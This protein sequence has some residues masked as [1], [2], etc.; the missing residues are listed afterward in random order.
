VETGAVL[1]LIQDVAAD[2]I[3]P[4]F[5]SL[6]EHQVTEKN[7]GD[8][9]TIADHESEELLTAALQEAYPAAVVLG[10]EAEGHDSGLIERFATAE[11][12]FTV[13]PVD[14]TKNF[15]SG[16][17]DHAV[18]VAETRA[19]SVTRSWI[20]QPQHEAAYVAERGA[21]AWLNGE[22]L[23]VPASSDT[24]PYRTA[25]RAWVGRELPGL[26]T[27]E[28]TWAC[29]GIDYPRLIAG[30]AR[31]I[32]YNHSKPWDHLPGALLLEEAGGHIGMLDGAPFDA[33]ALGGGLVGAPDR[34][35]YDAVV[36]AFARS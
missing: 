34:A 18:M 27:L 17:P 11:H 19:G 35:T 10:E 12:G 25:R 20:W 13:D 24:A 22:P 29:C 21:G 4:R 9:V 3:T 23:R 36:A 2:V 31:A 8:L 1:T 30:D 32:V 6:A 7:P 26:G 5:R 16:S 28:L 33:P 14:G 15:V